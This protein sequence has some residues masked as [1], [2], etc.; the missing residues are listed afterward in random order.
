MVW[1]S[2]VQETLADPLS[3]I[4]LP[5]SLLRHQRG[6]DVRSPSPYDLENHMPS[7]SFLQATT[8]RPTLPIY[9]GSTTLE[10]RLLSPTQRMEWESTSL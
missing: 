4:T 1:W 9:T 7:T 10:L 6:S 2:I 8:L 3:E 5:S